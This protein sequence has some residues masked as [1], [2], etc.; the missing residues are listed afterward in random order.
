MNVFNF[1]DR[2]ERDHRQTDRQE[3]MGY[4]VTSF[5]HDDESESILKNYPNIFGHQQNQ[6]HSISAFAS[7]ACGAAAIDFELFEPKFYPLIQG[8]AGQI[9]S[10][11]IEPGGDIAA[12]RRVIGSYLAEIQLKEVRLRL[13]DASQPDSQRLKEV[14]ANQGYDVFLI[15]EEKQGEA[16][17]IITRILLED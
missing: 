17:E 7:V 16:V 8:L 15:S 12:A 13:I 11:V 9:S 10:A 14:L 1:R 3:D 4:T 5:A 6:S 2:S